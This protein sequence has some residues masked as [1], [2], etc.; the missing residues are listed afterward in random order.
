MTGTTWA[1]VDT[2]DE[3]LVRK[4]LRGGVLLAPMSATIPSSI[5][6]SDGGTPPKPVLNV[7]TGYT[8]LGKLGDSG[9]VISHNISTSDINAWGDLEPVRRDITADVT[10]LKLTALETN[11]HTLTAYFGTDASAVDPDATTGEVEIVKPS[12]PTATYYRLLVLG[13]DGDD[14]DFSFIAWDLPRCN[15][16]SRGDMSFMSGDTGIFYD[17]EFTAFKDA[18]AGYSARF[19]AGGT[20]WKSLLSAMGWS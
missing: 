11:V 16:T 17:M 12:S 10:S 4:A 7:L 8:S 6:V 15:L 14:T 3:S 9:A 19:L 13:I 1:D 18:G 5:T 2:A 20:Q